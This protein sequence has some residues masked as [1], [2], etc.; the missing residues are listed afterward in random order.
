VAEELDVVGVVLEEIVDRHAGG[1]SERADRTHRKAA[2]TDPD[3]I[4]AIETLDEVGRED[5]DETGRQPHRGED[6]DPHRSGIAIERDQLARLAALSEIHTVD[7]PPPFGKAESALTAAGLS[8]MPEIYSGKLETL[9]YRTVRHPGHFEK[10]RFLSELG[11]LGG[12]EWDLAPGVRLAPR[13]VVREAIRRASTYPDV[14]DFVIVR[15]TA[16]GWIDDEPIRISVECLDFGEPA[17]GVSA[18]ER[19]VAY[20]LA[21]AARMVARGDM[22]RRGAFPP[23]RSIRWED[24]R[25]DLEGRGISFTERQEVLARATEERRAH[26]RS[27]SSSHHS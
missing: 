2:D 26:D 13:T 17:V 10:I 19:M 8:L 4:A 1:D 15:L 3:G 14:A 20:P 16:E 21:A 25:R 7:L 22:E 9:E 18:V 11:L 12:D 5:V 24:L 23:E 6:R 27:G